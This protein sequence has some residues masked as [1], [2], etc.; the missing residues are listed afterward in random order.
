MT[1]KV[2]RNMTELVVTDWV[3]YT[4]TT[5]GFGTITGVNFWS[6]RVG[7]NLEIMGQFTAG[8]PTAVEARIGLGFNGVAN[9]VTTLTGMPASPCGIY[10]TSNVGFSVHALAEA[11]LTYIT[12]TYN[13]STQAGLTKQNGNA[14]VTGSQVVT[15]RASV[16]IQGWQ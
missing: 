16:P 6:R 9:N 11:G 4:P 7:S 14:M 1:T 12:M 13:S 2:S 3:P 15:V 5:Q 10:L 8:T